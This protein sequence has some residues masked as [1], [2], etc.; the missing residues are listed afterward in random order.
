MQ[1]TSPLRGWTSALRAP[2]RAGGVKCKAMASRTIQICF[3][4]EDGINY[5]LFGLC[6]IMAITT[7]FTVGLMNGF[8]GAQY[9]TIERAVV[10]SSCLLVGFLMLFVARR[11]IVAVA[12]VVLLYLIAAVLSKSLLWVGLLYVL[13]TLLPYVLAL[14]ESNAD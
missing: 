2:A 9:G 8:E 6:M 10:F 13:V 4:V 5:L 14:V 7:P 11:N 12:I 1:A 3:H